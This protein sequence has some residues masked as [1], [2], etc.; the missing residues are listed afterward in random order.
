[1]N[2]FEIGM[3]RGIEQG[4]LKTMVKNVELSIR[5]FHVSLEEACEGLGISVKEYEKAK[6]R[7]L[8][9]EERENGE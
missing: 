4:S 6:Q 8:Q 9:W 7:I 2:I 3:E 5:N 1:M